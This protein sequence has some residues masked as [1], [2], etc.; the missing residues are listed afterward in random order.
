[1]GQLNVAKIVTTSDL[2]VGGTLDVAGNT[3]LSADVLANSDYGSA[4]QIYGV[5][6][7]LN[8]DHITDTINGSA[9]VSSIA[10]TSAGRFTITWAFTWPNDNYTVLLTSGGS[11]GAYG[12]DSC[13]TIGAADNGTTTLPTRWKSFT[14]GTSID[15][16]NANVIAIG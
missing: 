3:T 7:W 10:D 14:A 6:A 15:S 4:T 8:Y 2:E 13:G 5:R 16:D 11:G 12:D 9:G 1:M